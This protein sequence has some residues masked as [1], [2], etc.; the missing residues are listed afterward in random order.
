MG[1]ATSCELPLKRAVKWIHSL[2][3]VSLRVAVDVMLSTISPFFTNAAG[4]RVCP[5][6]RTAR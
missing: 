1:T 6:T 3:M 5:L 4:T 2:S